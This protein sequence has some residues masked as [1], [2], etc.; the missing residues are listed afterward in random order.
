MVSALSGATG[1]LDGVVSAGLLQPVGT[2][3]LGI[4]TYQL[5]GLV[6]RYLDGRR[7]A[8]IPLPALERMAGGWLTLLA[9]ASESLP[10]GFFQ[11]EPA[12]AARRT[13]VPPAAQ[14]VAR[15]RRNAVRWLE[16]EQSRLVAVT[17]QTADAGAAGLAV[18]LAVGLASFFE[19]RA[20]VDDWRRTHR[21]ALR[22]AVS[23]GDARGEAMILRGL[24]QLDIYADQYS[25]AA[26]KFHRS[27][28]LFTQLGDRRGAA[29]AL[30]GLGAAHHYDQK[31][32]DQA[33]DFYRL[34]LG[35]YE[36]NRQCPRGRVRPGRHR[37]G[38]HERRQCHRRPQVAGSRPPG[39]RCGGRPQPVRTCPAQTRASHAPPGRTRHGRRVPTRGDGHLQRP[40]QRPRRRQHQAPARPAHRRAWRGAAGDRPA[41]RDP[42]DVP[43]SRRSPVRSG[44][45][46]AFE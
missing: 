6:R 37:P 42:S 9:Y 3:T 27:L 17:E 34:A 5:S 36:K 29:A 44:R 2:D 41:R 22:A 43:H 39:R 40:R 24:G 1:T 26:G 13:T 31:K 33:L 15:A 18:D 10:V 25:A 30:S 21:A 11:V 45:S 23:A 19:L 46:A 14:V 35:L 4:P 38:G 7:T 20:N 32:N 8:S 28:A 12:A 16:S